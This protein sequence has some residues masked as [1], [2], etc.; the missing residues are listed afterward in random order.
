MFIITTGGGGGL[1]KK[2]QLFLTPAEK[3]NIGASIRIGWEI[4]CLPYAGFKKKIG[5]QICILERA[6]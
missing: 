6:N 5:R 2:N 4:Q 3:K 1:A